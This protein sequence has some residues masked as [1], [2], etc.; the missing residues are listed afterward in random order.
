MGPTEGHVILLGRQKERVVK[1]HWITFVQRVHSVVF[2]TSVL[3]ISVLRFLNRNIVSAHFS[4]IDDNYYCEREQECDLEFIVLQSLS[5]T[6]MYQD[7]NE[8]VMRC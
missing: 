4:M 3:Y 7:Q 2:V 8:D 6:Y 5:L 1:V